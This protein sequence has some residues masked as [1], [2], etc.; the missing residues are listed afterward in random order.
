MIPLLNTYAT[1]NEPLS[2]CLE[3]VSQSVNIQRERPLQSQTLV[4]FTFPLFT[5]PE[6]V[7]LIK[8]R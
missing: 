5:A 7:I 1:T 2:R 8:N 4:L 6:A 3:I